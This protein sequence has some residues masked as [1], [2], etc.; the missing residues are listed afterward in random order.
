MESAALL[1]SPSVAS[2]SCT[3]LLLFSK[4]EL[5]VVQ[6]DYYCWTERRNRS[7]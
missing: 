2:H 1:L 3:F 6:Q 4:F 7:I 5:Y